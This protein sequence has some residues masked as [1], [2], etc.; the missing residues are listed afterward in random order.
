MGSKDWDSKRDFSAFLPRGIAALA[1][2]LLK[3]Y[4]FRPFVQNE[5]SPLSVDL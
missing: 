4:F 1:N 3:L 5:I 2:D